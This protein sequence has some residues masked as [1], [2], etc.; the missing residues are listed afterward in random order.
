MDIVQKVVQL[1][2]GAASAIARLI[3][4]LAKLH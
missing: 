2:V 3:D 4:A 1:L